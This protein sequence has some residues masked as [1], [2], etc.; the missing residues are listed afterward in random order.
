MVVTLLLLASVGITLIYEGVARQET[1]FKA[2]SRFC[3]F[4]QLEFLFQDKIDPQSGDIAPRLFPTPQSFGATAPRIFSGSDI[5]DIVSADSPTR[6]LT[7][8]TK[9]ADPASAC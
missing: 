2:P 7:S 6:G 4:V 1:Y 8:L 3:T 5:K 9:S